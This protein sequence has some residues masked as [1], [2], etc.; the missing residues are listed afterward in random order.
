MHRGLV[1]YTPNDLINMSDEQVF[2]TSLSKSNCSPFL[3]CDRSQVSSR[4]MSPGADGV[5]VIFAVVCLFCFSFF[6]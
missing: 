1:F 2:R 3:L 6:Y 5:V 4:K